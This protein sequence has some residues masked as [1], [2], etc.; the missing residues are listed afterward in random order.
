MKSGRPVVRWR[1]SGRGQAA[2]PARP[3]RYRVEGWPVLL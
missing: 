1:V 3:A 2:G